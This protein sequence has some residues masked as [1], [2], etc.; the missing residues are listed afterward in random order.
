MVQK[1][2]RGITLDKLLENRKKISSEEV[3]KILKAIL[4]GLEYLYSKGIMHRD[5]K[6]AN[7]MYDEE[8]SKAVILDLGFACRFHK[9]D[10]RVLSAV[11]GTPLYMSP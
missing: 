5:L 4:H 1:L 10:E 9:N 2:E 11:V 8:N 7:I 3:K 6:P